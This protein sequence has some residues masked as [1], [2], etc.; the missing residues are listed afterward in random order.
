MK[1]I[2]KVLYLLSCSVVKNLYQL[3]HNLPSAKIITD[4]GGNKNEK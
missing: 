3:T 1:S 4:I 2:Y